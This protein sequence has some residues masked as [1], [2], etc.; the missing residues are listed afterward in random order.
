MSKAFAEKRIH[1]RIPT[2]TSLFDIIY[3]EKMRIHVKKKIRL[4]GGNRSH[5]ILLKIYRLFKIK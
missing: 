3:K 5:G 2:G 4:V 1:I